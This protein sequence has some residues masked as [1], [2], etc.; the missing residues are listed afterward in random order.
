VIAVISDLHAN[1]LALLAVLEEIERLGAEKVICLGDIVGYGPEPVEC[2]DTVRERCDVTLCGNHDFAL[3]YG[4]Q[5]FNPIARNSLEYHRGLIMPR[6]GVEDEEERRERWEF[7]KNLPHRYVEGEYLFVHGS[8]RNPVVEYLRKIDVLL[9]LKDKISENFQEVDWL[10]FNGHTHRAGVITSD[11]EFLEPE[12]ID[13]VFEPTFQQKA[14]INVGS[15]GQ[16]RDHNSRAAF[17]TIEDEKVYFHRVKYDV[18]AVAAKISATP[19]MDHSLAE[20]LLEGR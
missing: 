3:I 6:P 2:I 9:G 12:E 1:H 4:A 8:P 11:M 5:D 20:R 16:P 18:E 10:C 13:G 15:V 19:G 17:A 7:L 14:I